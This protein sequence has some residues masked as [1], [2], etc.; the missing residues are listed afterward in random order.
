MSLDPGALAALATALAWTVTAM[1]FEYAG[2][3]IGAFALN[4]LRLA[5]G[6]VFLGAY[7]LVVRGSFFPFDA[8]L[9]AWLGLGASGL[10]GLVAGD[11]LLFQAFI[12]CGSRIA[13]LVYA[14]AP[15]MTALLGFLVLGEKMALA[16]LAGMA[17]TLGGIA[18][19]VLGRPGTETQAGSGIQAQAKPAAPQA[20]PTPA[21]SRRAQAPHAQEQAHKP[22]QVAQARSTGQR[23]RTRGILLAF[24]ATLGQAVGLILGKSGA[25]NMDPFAGTQIRVSIALAAFAIIVAASGTW[26]GLGRALR[27]KKALVS[28]G[29]GSFFGPFLGVS[30]SLLAVQKTS[31]GL[32]SAI[33]SLTPIL[34][35]PPSVLILKEKTTARELAGSLLAVAGVF[36]LFMA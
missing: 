15:A 32:A 18:L 7:G 35:I 36:V 6:C 27:D 29:A 19:A 2:K 5:T 13:M 4:T 34:I 26:R 30:L 25:G 16:G 1:S 22:A 12:D 11:L 28:L 14:T 33:M 17:L 23:H 24:G 9:S 20:A 21:D 8:P 10:V 31:A 3:R